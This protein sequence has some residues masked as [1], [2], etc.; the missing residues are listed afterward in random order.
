MKISQAKLN[1]FVKRMVI[2]G[3]SEAE[4]KKF[5]SKKKAD[6]VGSVIFNKQEVGLKDSPDEAIE[7]TFEVTDRFRKGLV[8]EN[9]DERI[10]AFAEQLDGIFNE[11]FEDL[12]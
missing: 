7:I 1:Y 4:I 12:M 3:K 5:F 8:P 2:A 10:R 9:I 11:T 6:S